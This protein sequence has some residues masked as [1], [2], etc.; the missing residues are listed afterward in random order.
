MN[1]ELIINVK[2]YDKNR[3][4]ESAK[5]IIGRTKNIGFD[6]EAGGLLFD[7]LKGCGLTGEEIVALGSEEA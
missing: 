1:M 5:R 2:E 4:R 3:I 7:L 6:V